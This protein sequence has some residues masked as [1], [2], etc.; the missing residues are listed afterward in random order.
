M[1]GSRDFSILTDRM[2][3]PTRFNLENFFLSVPQYDLVTLRK[4]FDREQKKNNLE[5]E[6]DGSMNPGGRTTRTIWSFK[7]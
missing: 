5:I 3:R 6:P 4:E 1:V 2:V 7:N